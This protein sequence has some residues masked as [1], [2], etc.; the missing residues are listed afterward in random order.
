MYIIKLNVQKLKNIYF[1]N[2]NVFFVLILLFFE[3]FCII[4]LKLNTLIVQQ[5]FRF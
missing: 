1:V 3:Y 4:K 2:K 5:H